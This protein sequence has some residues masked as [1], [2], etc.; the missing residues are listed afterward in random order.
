MKAHP[1][2]HT[3]DHTLFFPPT[4]KMPPFCQAIFSMVSPRIWVWSNPNEETPQTHG[5]LHNVATATE[6]ERWRR[7]G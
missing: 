4:L 7:K 6:R 3:P 2:P 5:L 1:H